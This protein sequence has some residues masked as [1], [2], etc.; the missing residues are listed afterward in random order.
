VSLV[1][2]TRA[3]DARFDRTVRA[4]VESAVQSIEPD[5]EVLG[6]EVRNR[7]GDV[8]LVIAQVDTLQDELVRENRLAIQSQISQQLHRPLTLRISV[9]SR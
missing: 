6:I 9:S 5:A 4:A 8:L 2:W 3:G 7:D 1:L